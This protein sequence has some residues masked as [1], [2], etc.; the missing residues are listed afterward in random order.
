M[1]ISYLRPE[2]AH[3]G[4]YIAIHDKVDDEWLVFRCHEANK[5]AFIIVENKFEADVLDFL[6]LLS[7]PPVAYV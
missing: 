5:V 3:C 1:Q 4:N 6:W 2:A 7:V